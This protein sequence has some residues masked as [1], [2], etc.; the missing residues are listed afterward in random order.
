M[1]L[2]GLSAYTTYDSDY[3]KV[4]EGERNFLQDTTAV[5]EAIVRTI[6]ATAVVVALV[7]CRRHGKKSASINLEES[8]ITNILLLMGFA[9][10]Q[11]KR[12]SEKLIS[13]LNRLW[14]LYLDHEIANSTAAFL[15]AAST[16]TDPLSCLIAS[17]PSAFGPLHG[18]AMDLAYK[19]FRQVGSPENVPQLIAKVRAK[20]MRLFGY[21]HR[22][23]KTVD[24]RSKLM[25]AMLSEE[26]SEE[27]EK[28]KLLA[29]ALEIDRVAARDQYFISRN[30]RA[31]ADLYGAFVYEAL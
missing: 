13:C 25:R 8:F 15:L 27:V 20:K 16:L 7:Y 5:D 29:V 18:G 17:I 19:T 4:R 30:L 28:N 1:M 11:T 6:S 21:G 14:I 2:A 23:Y 31:N 9:E 22:I 12:P 26:L 10:T 3:K 24:P